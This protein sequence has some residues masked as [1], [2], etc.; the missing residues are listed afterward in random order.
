MSSPDSPTEPSIP[1]DPAS[2]SN[3]TAATGIGAVTASDLAAA[4]AP[5]REHRENTL[6]ALFRIPVFRRMW[7]AITFSSLGDWL[8]LLAN[9]A[10]AQ[11]LTRGQSIATQGVAISGVLLVRLAPDLLVGA[12]AAALADK[13]DRRKTVMAGQLVAGVLYAS[14]AIGYNLTTLYVAQFVIEAAGLF[15]QPANQVIWVSIV[16]K[17][18]LPT[19]NQISLFSV[20]GTVPVA[21]IVFALLSAADRLIGGAHSTTAGH[22]NA[23]IVIALLLNAVTFF[24]SAATV[25]LSRRDIPVVPRKREQEASVF[26]L[27]REGVGFVRKNSLIRGL[28]VGIIGAFAAGGV[29]AGVALLWVKTLSAG[30]AGYAIMF[31]TLFTGL[32]VGI[33]IGPRVLPRYARSFVFGV[34]IGGA[35][36]TLIVMSL[37]RNFVLADGLAAL[38]GVFAGMAWV[39]GYTLIGQEVEERLRGRIFAFVLSSVRLTLFATIALGPVLAGAFGSHAIPFGNDTYLRFSGPGLTL[40]LGGAVALG[41]S[42]YATSRATRSG[43]RFRDLVRH[44]VLRTGMAHRNDHPGLFVSVDGLDGTATAGYAALVADAVRA[45]GLTVTRTAEPTDSATGRHV[46]QLLRGDGSGGVEP[47]TAALLSAAD[48]AEHVA[49]TIRPALDRGEVVVCD[50]F[51]L[52]SL[53]LHGGGRGADVDRIRAVNAWSTG[54]LFPDL[55]LVVEA[56]SNRGAAFSGG[57]EH[58]ADIDADAVTQA[59]HNEVGAEPDRYL[60]CPPDVPDVLPE[61]VLA[62][63]TRLAESR[64]ALLT[65][66]QPDAVDVVAQP[67]Q[68]PGEPSAEHPAQAVP[69]AR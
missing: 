33:L 44:R 24:V 3:G 61:N 48:R 52:T 23:G 63:L 22:V 65:E 39:I 18:L 62:R 34:S 42:Y 7:A 10:L 36:V 59:L 57:G 49:A 50:R 25:F 47:E 21:A 46:A 28:Y 38:V 26:S 40:L 31:G 4:S 1:G 37:I 13:W 43:T 56:G 64:A 45:R 67:M 16:P 15:I 17:K 69:P 19:A 27:L 9:T 55:T 12:F 68:Q 5:R 66:P 53:A 29:T 41:V 32:A 30:N 14:I 58:V 6:L 2:T 35:G 11:Q 20:Y 51:L 8:G 54:G 60:M